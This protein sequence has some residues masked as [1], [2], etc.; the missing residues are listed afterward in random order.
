[1][2][3]RRTLMEMMV[4]GMMADKLRKA[5]EMPE[6]GGTAPAPEKSKREP[7]PKKQRRSLAER[8]EEGVRRDLEKM[9]AHP[10]E[11]D[12]G[13]EPPPET[14]DGQTPRGA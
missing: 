6:L 4:G 5:A 11:K 13:D 8:I 9:E 14:P 10:P 1:L 12:A 7:A 3:G 2:D